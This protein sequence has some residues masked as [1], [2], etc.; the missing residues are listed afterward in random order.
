LSP[1]GENYA[2]ILTSWQKDEGLKLAGFQILMN[3]N[4]TSKWYGTSACKTTE[5]EIFI[6]SG[7]NRTKTT[8]VTDPIK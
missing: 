7:V 5:R 2:T 1:K 8:I 6:E 4:G 3:E